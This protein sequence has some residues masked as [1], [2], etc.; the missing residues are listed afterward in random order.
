MLYVFPV[1]VNL[2]CVF[3]NRGVVCKIVNSHIIII[4]LPYRPPLLK[5]R[6]NRAVVPHFSSDVTQTKL[7]YIFCSTLF[8]AVGS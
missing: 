3:E 8:A 6:R 5:E 7:I 1:H 2:L 4:Y